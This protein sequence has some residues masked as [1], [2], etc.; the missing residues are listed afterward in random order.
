MWYFWLFSQLLPSVLPPAFQKLPYKSAVF[1]KNIFIILCVCLSYV[2]MFPALMCV[3]VITRN[4]MGVNSA[5]GSRIAAPVCVLVFVLAAKTSL[6]TKNKAA[7]ILTLSV[8]VRARV[9]QN[10]DNLVRKTC[11]HISKRREINEEQEG[12]WGIRRA[13]RG[14]NAV[15]PTD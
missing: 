3:V 13:C 10:V 5:V 14:R 2:V 12:R 1:Q 4:R 9:E 8:Y 11:E 6:S 15:W 7:R